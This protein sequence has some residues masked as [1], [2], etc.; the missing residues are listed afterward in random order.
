MVAGNFQSQIYIIEVIVSL[1]V[2]IYFFFPVYFYIFI[3]N[4]RKSESDIKGATPTTSPSKKEIE[5]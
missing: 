5:K 1:V 4:Y 3:S 2:I